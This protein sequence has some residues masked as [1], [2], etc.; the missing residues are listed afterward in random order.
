MNTEKP[1]EIKYVTVA[2]KTFENVTYEM[3]QFQRGVLISHPANCPL[4]LMVGG[5]YDGHTWLRRFVSATMRNGDDTDNMY[6]RS[7]E[8]FYS[9]KAYYVVYRPFKSSEIKSDQ[10]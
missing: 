4:G 9:E 2:G 7:G 3:S 8:I 5:K 10:K 1:S 6:Y